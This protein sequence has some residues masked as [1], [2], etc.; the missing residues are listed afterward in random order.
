[1]SGH[2]QAPGVRGSHEAPDLCLRGGGL[3][4][5][6]PLL[7]PPLTNTFSLLFCGPNVIDHFCDIL[8]LMRLA[9][10][11]TGV[12]DSAGFA[13]S[14]C[15]IISC[16]SLTVLSYVRILATVVQI[17]S[18]ASPW[19]AFSMCSSHLATVLL[20]YGTGSSAYM[21]PTAR[22]SPQQGRLAAVFYCILMPTLNPLI[23]SLKNKDMKGSL[24]KLYLQV[25]PYKMVIKILYMQISQIHC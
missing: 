22:Y 15:V 20:F 3:G 25:P 12:H 17:H 6:A 11:N 4:Q 9:C 21:Q 19:K 5:W 24:R 14:G 10:A 18:A 8:P 7:C 13:A 1:M 2:L 23:Y 16:F